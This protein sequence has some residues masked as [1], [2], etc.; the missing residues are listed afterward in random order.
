MVYYS[1]KSSI[2]SFH[3]AYLTLTWLFQTKITYPFLPGA[4]EGSTTSLAQ[5]WLL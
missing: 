1:F 4:R 3:Q 2:I 5:A